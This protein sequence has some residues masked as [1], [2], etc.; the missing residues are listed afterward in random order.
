MA[1]NKQGIERFADA[2][3]TSEIEFLLARARALGSSRAN[4]RFSEIGLRARG[5]AV[6]SLAAS[7]LNPT[8]RELASFLCLD[9][10]QI[11]ALV[12]ALEQKGLVVRQPA[13]NDRRTNVI[14]ATQQGQELYAQA[15]V[16][17]AAADQDALSALTA[18]E[19]ET[20]RALLSK[21]AF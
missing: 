8:Q 12:D 3:L 14:Q 13:P 4:E 1:S 9:A 7:G 17:S 21:V 2:E 18:S 5:Y 19:R 15:R 6:L 20:L 10:S 16:V 11:V